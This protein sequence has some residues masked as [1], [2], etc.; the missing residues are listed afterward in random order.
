MYTWFVCETAHNAGA[1]CVLHLSNGR[2][3]CLC[4]TNRTVDATFLTL[5]IHCELFVNCDFSCVTTRPQVQAISV[6]VCSR[7]SGAGLPALWSCDLFPRHHLIPACWL[8]LK[9]VERSDVADLSTLQASPMMNPVPLESYVMSALPLRCPS[10]DT[11]THATSLCSPERKTNPRI[12]DPAGGTINSATSFYKGQWLRN[13][14]AN[15]TNG[16]DLQNWSSP[17]CSKM[18]AR[19]I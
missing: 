19:E 3:M 2:D 6:S 11:G 18:V 8:T 4:N 14:S 13:L 10:I 1:E 9:L 7:W 16:K 12:I 5:E 17:S 15:S